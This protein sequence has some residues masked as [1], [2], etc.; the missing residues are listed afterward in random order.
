MN[1]RRRAIIRLSEDDLVKL[2]DLPLGYEV[3]GV[4]GDYR[5]WSIDVIVKGD[6]LAPVSPGV[7]PPVLLGR[8]TRDKVGVLK[9]EPSE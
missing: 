9:W 6:D 4:Y 3:I 8:L 5:S 1:E 7:E 2:L